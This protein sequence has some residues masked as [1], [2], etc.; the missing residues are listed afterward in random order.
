MPNFSNLRNNL[1]FLTKQFALQSKMILAKIIIIFE[2]WK[3]FLFFNGEIYNPLFPKISNIN[4]ALSLI[5]YITYLFQDSFLNL[6]LYLN[7]EKTN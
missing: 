3:Y 6:L 7:R 1:K 4:K 2:L 5:T